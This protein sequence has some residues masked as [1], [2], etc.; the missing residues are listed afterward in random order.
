MDIDRIGYIPLEVLTEA[1]APGM[2]D[3]LTGTFQPLDATLTG[4]TAVPGTAGVVEQTSADAFAIR[5]IGVATGVSLITRDDGDARYAGA[6]SGVLSFN[7]RTGAVTLT[8]G[9]VT[10]ALTYTPTSVTGLTGTQSVA[11]FKAGLAIASGDVSGLGS[12]A[13]LS[14]VNDSNWSGAD[15]AIANGGT[16]A[17]SAGA[18]LSNLGGQPLDA[19]LTALG[20]YNTNGLL[21]QIAADTFAGRTITGTANQ[22]TVTNGDGVSGNPTISIP[23][24]IIAGN[25]TYAGSTAYFATQGDATQRIRIGHYDSSSVSFPTGL[26][27]AQILAGSTML[28]IATRDNASAVI[29]FRVG[30]GV[31][32]KATL[33]TT[34]LNL[35]SG[36]AYQVN[37]LQVVGARKTGWA[38]A[39]GTATRTTFD[40]ATVTLPQLA[41]RL[42][43]LIDDLHGT[44]GHG[45]IGT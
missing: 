43:A 31:A 45:L 10:G 40:T 36:V 7:T 34:A 6:G 25:I 11:A 39:T 33:S 35:A 37:A 8:S 9:D 20:A 38:T 3:Q 5:A 22:I 30:S 26:V 21:T 28:D 41:E 27:A 14:S 2:A 16:G 29:N 44:A 15:L 18:A 32:I 13:T 42:K 12:L 23:S 1:Q 19:T 4:L 24:T 17:S